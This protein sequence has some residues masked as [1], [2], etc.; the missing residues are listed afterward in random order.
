MILKGEA[1]C[2]LIKIICTASLFLLLLYI[3]LSVV[4]VCRAEIGNTVYIRADGS[5]DP[6]TAPL[7]KEDDVYVLTADISDTLVI[8]RD[9]IV[10]DGAGY[11]IRGIGKGVGLDLSGRIGVTIRNFRILNF[12]VG[13]KL[14]NSANNNILKNSITN[15]QEG[16]RLNLSEDNN[17]ASNFIKNN[18][19]GVYLVSSDNNRVV[20]NTVVYNWYGIRV[21][22]SSNCHIYQNNVTRNDSAGIFLNS[23]LSMGNFSL[24]ENEVSDNGVGIWFWNSSNNIIYHNNFVNNTIQ[25]SL[26]NSGDNRWD[27]GFEGNYWSDY[28]G[29]DA[30]K[31]AI[32]DSPYS[33]DEGNQDVYPL[34]GKFVEFTI[35]IGDTLYKI[36]T[37]CNSTVFS[38]GNGLSFWL[39]N[40]RNST[41]CRICIPNVLIEP[42]YMIIVGP[43]YGY[44]NPLDYRIVWENGTHSWVYFEYPYQDDALI[45]IVRPVRPFPFWFQWWFW[46]LCILAILLTVSLGKYFQ[47]RKIINMYKEQF[48]N[49]RQISH[50]DMARILFEADVRR[51]REKLEM[52]RRKYGIKVRHR[53]ETF[54][55]LLKRTGIERKFKE[56]SQK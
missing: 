12:T 20:N 2:P 38:E 35:K 44:D 3:P 49:I 46:G 41:F 55:D 32:G 33:I 11:T 10:V 54:E 34:M 5:V 40:I 31:D 47:Q 16:V 21:V 1:K 30:N 14:E 6:P 51:C 42:P 19:Y 7:V 15:C 52:L 25:V 45:A 13:I 43:P 18:S 28:R 36:E 48:K 23:Y 24:Y 9:Y 50:F 56:R 22:N 29:N 39:R 37:V 26:Y 27:N 53:E 8:E 4:S 17:I